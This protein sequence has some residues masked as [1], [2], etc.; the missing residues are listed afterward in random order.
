MAWVAG[1]FE[2]EFKVVH[3]GHDFHREESEARPLLSLD[4]HVG[5]DWGAHWARKCRTA[6]KLWPLFL[7][8]VASTR[9]KG[10]SLESVTEV[11]VENSP[12]RLEPR[13]GGI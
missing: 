3:L 11:I 5:A 9:A 6:P 8:W 4:V 13:M 1:V 10:R 2:I 12:G 7:P